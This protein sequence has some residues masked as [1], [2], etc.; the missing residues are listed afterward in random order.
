[1]KKIII[2]LLFLLI[3]TLIFAQRWKRERFD[4]FAAV[5]TNHFMG[6]LGGG[7]QDAAHFFG[8]RD[9]DWEYTRPT[10]QFGMR[11]RILQELTVKPIFTY[12]YLRGDDASSG[13]L[14]RRNRNLSFRTHLMEF[15][16]QVEYYFLPEKEMAKYT[17]SSMRTINR[18]CAYGF[19]G[20]GGFF[21]NPQAELDGQWHNLQ[22][23]KTEGQDSPYS[24]IAGYFSLGLGAKYHIQDRWSIGIE[25]SN[26]YTTTDYI[27]DAHDTYFDYTDGSIAD[28]LADRHLDED[29]NPAPDYETGQLYR[30][31]PEYNDAYILTMIT[32][33]YRFK[34]SMRSL[35]KF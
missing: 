30:G 28:Q 7:G 20:G 16:T 18:L 6:D 33:Y 8:V 13:S 12:G 19:L 27:D 9:M 26:R 24:K 1:M 21:F 29:G 14:G 4:A 22:P 17:F 25:M 2:P 23:L 31:D 11:I 3:P 34:F 5:G 15:G 32:G 10:L 35:P